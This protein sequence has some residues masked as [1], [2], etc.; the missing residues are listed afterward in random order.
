[1]NVPKGLPDLRKSSATLDVRK[2]VVCQFEANDGYD[3][4]DVPFGTPH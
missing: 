1:M 4:F 3:L 2:L